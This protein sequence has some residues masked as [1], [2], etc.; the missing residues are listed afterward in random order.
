MTTTSDQPKDTRPPTKYR[1]YCAECGQ[2]GRWIY[3]GNMAR[4]FG[5]RHELRHNYGHVARIQ[6]N[7]GH[8]YGFEVIMS[9]DPLHW[10]QW[11][12]GN[13][14]L[15]HQE[16]DFPG[17]TIE[18]MRGLALDAAR[19]QGVAVRVVTHQDTF[20]VQAL[21][22]T[23]PQCSARVGEPCEPYYCICDDCMKED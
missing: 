5:E 16:E 23:C 21:V 14:W 11:L 9:K 10:D 19:Q 1:W 3:E 18:V 7:R 12:D 8:E 4:V 15:L 22:P 13:V 20:T 2:H 6:D 17:R